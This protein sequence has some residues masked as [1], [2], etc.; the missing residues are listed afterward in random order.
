MLPSREIS[1]KLDQSVEEI[2]IFF[3]SLLKAPQSTKLGAFSTIFLKNCPIWAKLGYFPTIISR[4]NTLLGFLKALKIESCTPSKLFSW[5]FWAESLT[6]AHQVT[7]SYFP[8]PSPFI[9]VLREICWIQKIGQHQN[10]MNWELLLT[11]SGA[12]EF[13][14]GHFIPDKWFWNHESRLNIHQSMW[15]QWKFCKNLNQR[16]LT[17]RWPLTSLLLRPYVWLYPRIIVSKSHENTSKYVDTVNLL[18][19]TWTK[20]HWPLDDR[21]PHI[22]WGH[23]CESTHGS[24]CPISMGIHL[25]MRIQW[26]IL[27]KLPHTYTYYIH[28][29][30]YTYYIIHILRTESAIT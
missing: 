24:L 9:Y 11:W 22:C 27:Q 14:R 4:R 12:S 23:M 28:T 3:L 20:G 16:S 8:P 7:N 15:I 17:A 19:K 26:S 29:D 13:Y 25:C 30:T 6:T 10:L 2:L 5:I 1:R 21:W 18:A